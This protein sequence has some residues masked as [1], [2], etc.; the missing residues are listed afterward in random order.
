MVNFAV[1]KR[2]QDNKEWTPMPL[3]Q[4]LSILATRFWSAEE[5]RALRL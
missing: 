2:V 4:T 1:L 3:P 5:T